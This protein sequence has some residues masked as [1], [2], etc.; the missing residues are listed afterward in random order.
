M[1]Q[2]KLRDFKGLLC[3]MALAL[4]LGC[5]DASQADLE[6]GQAIQFPENT[7]LSIDEL[8]DLLNA[9]ELEPPTSIEN[10]ANRSNG[11]TTIGFDHEDA[12]NWAP[13]ICISGVAIWPGYIQPV[14]SSWAY[15]WL[16]DGPRTNF[17]PIGEGAYYVRG[18]AF[19]SDPVHVATSISGKQWFAFYMKRGGRI[20]FD[21]TGIEVMDNPVTLW[22]LDSNN[23]WKYWPNLSLGVRNLGNHAKNIKEFHLSSA[24]QEVLE[25]W[26]I[27]NIKVKPL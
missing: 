13:D 20:N 15:C 4:F 2:V 26:K 3:L 17:L 25:H 7:N 27:D 23:R 14:S 10:S 19:E 18:Y 11:I 22:F 12:C 21:L 24:S 9:E 1:I 5:E 16:S 8:A 6:N